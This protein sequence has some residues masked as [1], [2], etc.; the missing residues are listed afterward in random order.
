M[1]DAPG[2]L[3][4]RDGEELHAE[5]RGA[6]KARPQDLGS[7]TWPMLEQVRVDVSKQRQRLGE[8]RRCPLASPIPVDPRLAASLP[9]CAEEAPTDP[10]RQ[11]LHDR[12][13]LDGHVLPPRVALI[14]E[15]YLL[16]PTG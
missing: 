2:W 5:V 15:A 16:H 4:T 7:S 3:F 8:H 10:A 1:S 12:F 9:P 14:G 6:L 13:P 11:G